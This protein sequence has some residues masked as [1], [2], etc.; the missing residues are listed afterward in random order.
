MM[1]FIVNNDFFKKA[2]L[3]MSKVV[4]PKAPLPILTG[5][6]IVAMKDCVTLIGSNSDIVIEKVLRNTISRVKVVDVYKTGSTVVSAKLL[7]DIVKKFP[8]NIR[9]TANDDHLVTME[10]DEIIT[11][12]NGFN[13]DEYPPLPKVAHDHYVSVPS[14]DLLDIAKQTVFA[15]S[16]NE[17]KP[18]LTG[19]HLAFQKNYLSCVATDSHRLSFR[20]L[21]ITSNLQRSCIVPSKAFRELITIIGS[22]STTPID[23]VITDHNVVFKSL[24]TTLYSRL[25]EGNYPS[26]SGLLQQE[27][28]TIMTLNTTKLLNGVDRACIFASERRN[29]T[30]HFEVKGNSNFIISSNSTEVGKI[31]ETQKLNSISGETELNISLDGS[32]L[33]DTLKVI[34][35]E[36]VR[37]SFSGSMRPVLIEPVG[38]DLHTY[39]IS[40]VRSY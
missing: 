36:E 27:H 19:V 15:V 13:P 30:I 5:I 2:I 20:K 38:N 26:V 16:K 24:F 8:R 21:K 4:S 7:H 17:A 33:I 10:S 40:P 31:E 12:L 37:L 28:K 3:E 9:L 14:K 32:F 25:I 6:K 22:D 1:E 11:T 34:K 35:E 29:H 39:L 23:I 18:I